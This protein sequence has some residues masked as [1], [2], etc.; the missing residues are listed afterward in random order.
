MTKILRQCAVSVR[1]EL[2]AMLVIP[3]ISSAAVERLFSVAGQVVSNR[4]CRLSDNHIDKM[5][6]LRDRLKHPA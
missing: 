6:F 5:I 1:R 2:Q 4:R 3:S